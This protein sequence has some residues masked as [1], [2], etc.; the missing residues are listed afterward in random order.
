M[1]EDIKSI[2]IPDCTINFSPP[3]ISYSHFVIK[4]ENL[5]AIIVGNNGSGKSSLL[6]SFTKA[7]PKVIWAE[8]KNA[9]LEVVTSTCSLKFQRCDQ[10]LD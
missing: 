2:R 10:F 9:N 8:T 4:K 1:S 7:I 6:L 5:P 3:L